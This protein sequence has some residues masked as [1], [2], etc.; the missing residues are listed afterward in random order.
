MNCHMPK[1]C[2][3]LLKTSRSHTIASPSAKVSVESGRPNACNLCHLDRSI[4]WAAET[5]EGWYGIEPP[6]LADT[7]RSLASGVFWTMTGDAG[8]RALMA[9][10]MGSEGTQEASGTEWMLPYLAKLLEDPY[11]AVR[12][13]AVRS[14]QTLAGYEDFEHDFVAPA[15]EHAKARQSLLEGWAAAASEKD[16]RERFQHLLLRPDG[17]L[18]QNAFENLSAYRNDKHVILAE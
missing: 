6:P 15:D 14:L 4:A 10:H 11:D 1:T 12:F 9:W 13:N 3:A 17:S 18:R 16:S 5:M 7:D 8:Q 2:W